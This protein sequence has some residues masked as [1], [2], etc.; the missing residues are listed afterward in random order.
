[1]EFFASPDFVELLL[2]VLPSYQW[3]NYHIVNKEVSSGRNPVA[4]KFL[5]QGRADDV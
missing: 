5:V 1:M 4:L 2:E 3:V